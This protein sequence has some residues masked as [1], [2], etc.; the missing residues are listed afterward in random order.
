VE[1][2][3]Q[4][5]GSYDSSPPCSELTLRMKSQLDSLFVLHSISSELTLRKATSHCLTGG[6][7]SKKSAFLKS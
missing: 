7:I 6:D 2:D 3:L 4:L 1:N 5:R